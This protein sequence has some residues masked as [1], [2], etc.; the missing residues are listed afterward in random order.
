MKKTHIPAI[1]T[2]LRDN[3]PGMTCNEIKAKLPYIYKVETIRKCLE[4][5]PD[6]FIDRWIKGAR[7]QYHAVWCVVV[8]PPHCPHPKDRY[9]RSE[10]KSSE[11]QTCTTG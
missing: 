6:A 9:V 3:E 11:R 5:M 7:G 10:W 2:L 4:R 8:P 1:R